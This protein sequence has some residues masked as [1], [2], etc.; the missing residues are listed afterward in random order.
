[1]G[2][3]QT[4]GQ[5]SIPSNIMKPRFLAFLI[6]CLASEAQAATLINNVDIYPDSQPGSYAISYHGFPEAV[7]SPISSSAYLFSATAIAEEFA[8]YNVSLGDLI[9]KSYKEQTARLISNT[10]NPGTANFNIAVNESKYLGYW[11]GGNFFFAGGLDYY[12]W[13][14]VSR[15]PEGLIASES[16]TSV[17]NGIR[18]G[19]F[20]EV[21]E[22]SVSALVLSATALSLRRRRTV[23][24]TS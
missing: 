20:A 8:F 16:A 2:A 10:G 12:G 18:V 13:V 24:L 7:F 1:V 11:A 3:H 21:P 5:L 23:A 14:R 22:P 15:T 19:S 6:W 4:F 9:D 17:G